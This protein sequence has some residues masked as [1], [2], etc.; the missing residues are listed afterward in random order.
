MAMINGTAKRIY[1]EHM[2]MSGKKK[3]LFL[4]W[5]IRNGIISPIII[6]L[7]ILKTVP[8]IRPLPTGFWPAIIKKKPTKM[9]PIMALEQYFFCVS[10]SDSIVGIVIFFLDF[11]NF[12]DLA[13]NDDPPADNPQNRKNGDKYSF[14]S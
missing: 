11:G 3:V 10:L 8:R 12:K 1:L 13:I 5:P 7:T 2:E 6:K 14:G 9:A 4:D